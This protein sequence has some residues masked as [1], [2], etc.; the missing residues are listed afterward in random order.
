V[1]ID[2]IRIDNG[3]LVGLAR[4]KLSLRARPAIIAIGVSRLAIE[5]VTVEIDSV[6]SLTGNS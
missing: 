6:P 3:Q 2:V 5:S 4:K 1:T